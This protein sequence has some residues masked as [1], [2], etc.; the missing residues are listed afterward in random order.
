MDFCHI[1][2]QKVAV[3]A[4][5]SIRLY[6][7][8]RFNSILDPLNRKKIY[9]ACVWPILT[10]GQHTRDATTLASWQCY[11]L[12]NG[13]SCLMD[14]WTDISENV[15]GVMFPFIFFWL[16]SLSRFYSLSLRSHLQYPFMYTF[17]RTQSAK[18]RFNFY[19]PILCHYA[20]HPLL[21]GLY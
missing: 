19:L 14:I 7:A 1:D 20:H 13:F 10:Y 2:H 21:T 8:S 15:N 16:F 17:S 9:S 3:M 5:H 12:L 6:G 11:C 18:L 4:M